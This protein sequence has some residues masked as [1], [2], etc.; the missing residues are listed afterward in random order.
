M[1]MQPA[2]DDQYFVQARSVL[3]VADLT[4]VLDATRQLCESVPGGS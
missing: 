2:L 4:E 3:L 1:L